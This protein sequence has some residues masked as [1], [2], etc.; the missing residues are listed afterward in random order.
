M[1][2]RAL[3]TAQ[4][5]LSPTFRSGVHDLRVDVSD[6]LQAA[7]PIEIAVTVFLPKESA[8]SVPP[9]VIFGVPGGGYSRFAS[10]RAQLWH[11]TEA[12]ARR[13]SQFQPR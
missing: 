8:L 2:D 12:W 7:Q 11:L 3:N 4:R 5:R 6:R 9:I 1:P 13:L 10:T